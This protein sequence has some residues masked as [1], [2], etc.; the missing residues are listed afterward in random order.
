ME[1]H[2]FLSRI[3]PLWNR[4]VVLCDSWNMLILS[5]YFHC[6]YTVTNTQWGS[7]LWAPCVSRAMLKRTQILEADINVLDYIFTIIPRAK[8]HN[9]NNNNKNH[10]SFSKKLQI[11]N[12]ATY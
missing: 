8:Y 12:V 4:E 2:E 10:K 3:K 5:P 7:R 9:N 11:A 6:K 1:V